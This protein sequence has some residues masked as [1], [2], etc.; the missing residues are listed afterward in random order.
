MEGSRAFEAAWGSAAAAACLA[1]AIPLLVWSRGAAGDTVFG[2][3][4]DPGRRLQLA[5]GIFALAM[6][7]TN[8]GCRLIPHAELPLVHPA[9]FI[10]TAAL[11]AGLGPRVVVLAARRARG[12]T[13][14]SRIGAATKVTVRQRT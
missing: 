14:R 8:L 9:F 4:I 7:F 2:A 1:L 3:R 11:L 13:F 5:Y 10:V 6:A 12:R